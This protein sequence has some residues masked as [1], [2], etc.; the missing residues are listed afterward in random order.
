MNISIALILFLL[1]TTSAARGRRRRSFPPVLRGVH[2][3]RIPIDTIYTQQ[4][5]CAIVD[6][7]NVIKEEFPNSFESYSIL[8]TCASNRNGLITHFAGNFSLESFSFVCDEEPVISYDKNAEPPSFPVTGKDVVCGDELCVFVF[9]TGN[10]VFLSAAISPEEARILPS[11]PAI[12][13]PFLPT[14]VFYRFN[15]K[16]RQ[17]AGRMVK[18]FEKD[19]TGSIDLRAMVFLGARSGSCPF[20]LSPSCSCRL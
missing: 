12:S 16:L 13:I 17:F 10:Q 9:A 19:V 15:G 20:P 4:E 3:P 2:Y 11:K 14:K 5:R 7:K 8:T 6:A 18:A 1:V